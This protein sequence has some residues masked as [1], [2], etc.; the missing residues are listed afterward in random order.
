[1]NPAGCAVNFQTFQLLPFSL[2][3]A[4]LAVT[5]SLT[6]AERTLHL[7]FRL[8]G[9]LHALLLPEPV[10]QPLRRDE[11]WRTTCCECFLRHPGSA[12]YHELNVSPNGCWNLYRFDG[13]RAGGREEPAISAIRTERE[14]SSGL[15]QLRCDVP[16]GGLSAAGSTLELGIS[17][18]LEHRDGTLSYWALCHPGEKPD[19]HHPGAF[20]LR[21]QDV[22][23]P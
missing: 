18:V 14:I 23:G 13:Y 17:C 1:M 5:G 12:A 8:S 10:P 16:L 11:L 19:F 6:V 4:A 15:L 2:P 7:V 20:R 3:T 22:H 21:L 9:E